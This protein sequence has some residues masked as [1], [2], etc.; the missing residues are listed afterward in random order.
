M[1]YLI[2][3]ATSLTILSTVAEPVWAQSE[4]S[5]GGSSA[6]TID[7]VVPERLSDYGMRLNPQLG[8]SSFETTG[9]KKASSSGLS[10]GLTVEFGQSLRKFETGLIYMEM[11]KSG[12]LTVP[13]MAKIRLFSMRAQSWYAKVG[14]A[15]AFETANR[16]ADVSNLDVLAGLGIGGRAMINN[17]V[18][19]ILEATYHRGILSADERSQAYDVYNQGLLVLAGFSIRI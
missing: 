12:F 15:T 8:S 14:F 10:G 1:K 17:K 2:L 13:M 9:T 19:L 3:A 6:T 18:D 5:L 16:K 11:A 7:S 4:L